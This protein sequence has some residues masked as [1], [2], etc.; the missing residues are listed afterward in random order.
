MRGKFGQAYESVL[1][2]L[3]TLLLVGIGVGVSLDLARLAAKETEER[4]TSLVG[5]SVSDGVA[6]LA[7]S[8]EELGALCAV[9]CGIVLATWR[10]DVGGGGGGRERRVRH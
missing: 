2:P 4:R 7:A 8:L 10:S 9:A 6:L 1:V 5:S 3:D